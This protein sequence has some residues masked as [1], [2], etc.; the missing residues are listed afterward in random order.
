MLHSA[1][2]FPLSEIPE[3]QVMEQPIAF[4]ERALRYFTEFA[5]VYVML[6]RAK[7]LVGDV[8]AALI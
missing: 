3:K 5:A 6:S 8:Q 4:A 1:F 2:V 7:F